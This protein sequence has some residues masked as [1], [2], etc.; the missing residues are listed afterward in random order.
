MATPKTITVN[1]LKKGK[2]TLRQGE[3]DV[4]ET[5]VKAEFRY[6]YED[7]AGDTI[8]E[9][10]WGRVQEE[11]LWTAIPTSIQDAFLVIQNYVYEKA[12]TKE[13]MD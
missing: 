11:E 8:K 1:D 13:G 12:L 7:P 9:L 10:G 6:Q 5:T 2:I 4:G 3:N